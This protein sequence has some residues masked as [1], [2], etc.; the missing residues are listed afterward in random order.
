MIPIL[1][2]ILGIMVLMWSSPLM[3]ESIYIPKYFATDTCLSG[4][5]LIR[6]LT[7]AIMAMD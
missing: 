6:I 7:S 5:L 4:S 3:F 1:V 2:E